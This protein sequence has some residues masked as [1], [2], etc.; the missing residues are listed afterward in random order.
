MRWL[1][2]LL[3]LALVL[4]LAAGAS[5]ADKKAKKAKKKAQPPIK[6]VVTEVQKDPDGK[7]GTITV[8]VQASKKAKGDAPASPTPD[9]E[10]KFRITAQTKFAKMERVAKGEKK[11]GDGSFQDVQQGGRVS[12][13]AAGDKKDEAGSVEIVVRKKAKAKGAAKQKAPI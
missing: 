1:Q 6:G 12:I 11:H 13:T 10:K 3:T 4:A 2:T 5:A 7:T 8:K 9:T